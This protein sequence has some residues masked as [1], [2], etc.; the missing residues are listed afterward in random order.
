[1]LGFHFNPIIRKFEKRDRNHRDDELKMQLSSCGQ[2][3]RAL[4][5]IVLRIDV[6]IT[7][8]LLKIPNAH[9]QI[10]LG[11]REKSVTNLASL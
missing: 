9:Q 4:K 10:C 1:M 6:I 8:Q 5:V 2:N 7:A 3:D 11:S